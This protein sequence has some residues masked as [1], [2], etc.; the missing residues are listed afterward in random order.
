MTPLGFHDTW[1]GSAIT[2]EVAAQFALLS[3][4]AMAVGSMTA[5]AG[6]LRDIV[7]LRGD[8]RDPGHR[9]DAR[10]P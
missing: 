1:L 7:R 8:G 9:A 3:A 5:T 6:T 4:I 10:S 2:L